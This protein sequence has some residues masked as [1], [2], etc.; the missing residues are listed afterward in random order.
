[1]SHARGKPVKRNYKTRPSR[2]D[3]EEP[4]SGV[5]E[6]REPLRH[7]D[8]ERGVLGA[9]IADYEIFDGK[10]SVMDAVLVEGCEPNWFFGTAHQLIFEAMVRLHEARR[11][12]DTRTLLP[13]LKDAGELDTVGGWA[14]LNEITRA[15][16][17]TVL[18]HSHLALVREQYLL[19]RL[20]TGAERLKSGVYA[21]RSSWGEFSAEMAPVMEG[22][23]GAL[24]ATTERRETLVQV[25]ERQE[26][27]FDDAVAGVAPDESKMRRIS[28]GLKSMDERLHPLCAETGDGLVVVGAKP[29]AGKSSLVRQLSFA[30]LRAGGYIQAFL[31]ET[32]DEQYTG[33]CAGIMSGVPFR[34]QNDAVLLARWREQERSMIRE[35][36]TYGR[37][38]GGE[39]FEQFQRRIEAG[40]FEERVVCHKSW[41][42]EMR[43]W[44]KCERLKVWAAINRLDHI[45]AAAKA[46]HAKSGRTD[47]IIVDYLQEVVHPDSRMEGHEKLGDICRRLKALGKEL[48]AVVFLICSLNREVEGMP[49]RQNLRG[50]GDIE[51]AADRIV[52]VHV[53]ECDANGVKQGDERRNL[54]VQIRQDK[55]RDG[56]KGT[57]WSVFD[58]HLTQFIDIPLYTQ[59]RAS[60]GQSESGGAREERRGRPAGVKNGEG[61][62]HKFGGMPAQRG[63]YAG[64]DDGAPM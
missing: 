20:V 54:S 38:Q 2:G 10:K 32:S 36:E 55:D 40:L 28:W 13:A 43:E 9:V 6:G 1:M 60:S 35:G 11:P 16:D 61:R 57:L 4:F 8:A 53:P 29:G 58:R 64:S 56:G 47:L 15:T 63:S 31:L 7:E 37:R 5:A 33:R 42:A 14:Y 22:M 46:A 25:L 45:E 59:P 19:R 21:P 34:E 23:L 27:K 51:F 41:L 30:H 12:C 62:Q 52:F 39:S 44:A 50:S 49:T 48:G 18:V 24:R 17:T 26:K 3:D